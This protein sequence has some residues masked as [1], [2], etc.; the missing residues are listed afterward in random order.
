MIQIDD[1]ATFVAVVEAGS[2][3]AA[4]TRLGTTKSVVSRRLGDLEAELGAT[5]IERVVRNYDL[6]KLAPAVHPRVR[7]EHG[8]Y[9]SVGS[10][11]H[12]SSPRA[13]GTL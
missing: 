13:R 9:R 8:H 6:V 4:A 12:G 5:L 7:G 3:T 11:G 2:L 1:M 10:A